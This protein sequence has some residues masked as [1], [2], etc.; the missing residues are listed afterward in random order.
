[1]DNQ[2]N[3][4]EDSKNGLTDEEVNRLLAD[5]LPKLAQS[6]E[7][8][9]STKYRKKFD[10]GD[11]A[12]TVCRTI[13][14]NRKVGKLVIGSEDEFYK[15]VATIVSRKIRKKVRWENSQKRSVDRESEFD[16]D[17]I[18]A[19]A[20]DPSPEATERFVD[21]LSDLGDNLDPLAVEILHLKLDQ[22]TNREIADKVGRVERTVGRKIELIKEKVLEYLAKT[23][24]EA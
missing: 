22:H 21:M 10:G 24:D 2:N 17:I 13:I 14:K 4:S 18:A 23:I 1:M 15:L 8:R 5:F 11:I 19:I 20:N 6:A 16:A 3:Q 12:S 7:L 9:I